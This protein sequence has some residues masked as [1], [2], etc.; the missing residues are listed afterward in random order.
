V[1]RGDLGTAPCTCSLSLH[2]VPRATHQGSRQAID[3]TI[4]GSL[5]E[6]S[7]AVHLG[8]PTLSQSQRFPCNQLP[9][10]VRSPTRSPRTAVSVLRRSSNSLTTIVIQSSARHARIIN[11][12]WF[13]H[14]SFCQDL[15]ALSA[16]NGRRRPQ[17]ARRAR[18]LG[19]DPVRGRPQ[20]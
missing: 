17:R 10:D 15:Q 5:A 18:A 6:S 4:A 1:G 20:G 13:G 11:P 14:D 16:G 2:G 12:M 3:P 7:K 8:P 19:D 9:S